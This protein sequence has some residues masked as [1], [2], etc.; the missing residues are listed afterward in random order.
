MSMVFDTG[1]GESIFLIFNFL[2]VFMPILIAIIV[3]MF[4][5]YTVKK[6]NRRADER[7]QIERENLQVQQKMITEMNERIINIEKMLKA[8]E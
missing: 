3:M 2:S 7:L 5:I 8:V 6:Y 4:V 1:L